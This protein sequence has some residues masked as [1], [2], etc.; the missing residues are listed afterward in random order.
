V[1][2]ARPTPRLRLGVLGVCCLLLVGAVSGCTTTQE[3]AAKKQAESKRFLKEREA[4]RDRRE[5]ADR[6]RSER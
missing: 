4:R 1:R 3:T 2:S 6:S 5:K